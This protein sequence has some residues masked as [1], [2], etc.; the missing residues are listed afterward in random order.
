MDGKQVLD[1]VGHH[2]GC[3]CLEFTPHPE[4]GGGK[5]RCKISSGVSTIEDGGEGEEEH[6]VCKHTCTVCRQTPRCCCC[7][8]HDTLTC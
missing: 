3:D 6:D 1:F 4:A 8:L 7:L 5:H 2:Q